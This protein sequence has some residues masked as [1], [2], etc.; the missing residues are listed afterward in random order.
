MIF[1]NKLYYNVYVSDNNTLNV[2]VS[3][4]RHSISIDSDYLLVAVG[5]DLQ[6]HRCYKNLRNTINDRSCWSQHVANK[7]LLKI[8]NTINWDLF[9]IG[10]SLTKYG[11]NRQFRDVQDVYQNQ[12]NTTVLGLYKME[13]RKKIVVHPYLISCRII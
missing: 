6:A 2:I 7:N 12:V 3:G 8:N 13:S 11:K 9:I 5:S 10:G 4:I 1:E